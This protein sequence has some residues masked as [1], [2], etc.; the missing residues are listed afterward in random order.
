MSPPIRLS[1]ARALL[2]SPGLAP[3]APGHAARVGFG[4]GSIDAP[5]GGGLLVAALHEFYAAREGDEVAAAGLALLLA[6][7]CGRPGPLLWLRE[8]RVLRRGR[9]YG[10]GVAALGADPARLLLV[11]AP[12]TLAL[13]RAGAEA[14][15]CTA[16]AAVIIEPAGR[17]DAID[18]TATRRLGLAAARSGVLTLLLRTGVPVPSA[19]HS[20]WQV[21]AAASTPLAAQAP[22]LSAIDL[23]LLRHRGGLADVSA[24]LEWDSD[25]RCF[26]P[27][28][29]PALSGG[30]SAPVVDRARAATSR[31]A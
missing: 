16:M 12:D 9:P 28:R 17:A 27:T 19:A 2:P 8:D 22:G 23:R 25:R 26:A 5:L 14:V 10:M 7:R 20:R 11:Q 3:V 1:A 15:A 30:P 13:L 4:D 18:L 29:S 31:A 6:L 24:R 21:A